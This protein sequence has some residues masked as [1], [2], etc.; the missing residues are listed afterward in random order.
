[1]K[2]RTSTIFTEDKDDSDYEFDTPQQETITPKEPWSWPRNS[3]DADGSAS[4][5]IPGHSEHDF[6]SKQIRRQKGVDEAG[7]LDQ[8]VGITQDQNEP[9]NRGTEPGHAFNRQRRLSIIEDMFY[10]HLF[11]SKPHLPPSYWV[12][13]TRPSHSS[14]NGVLGG[15]RAQ[16]RDQEIA[17]LPHERLPEY[18][19]E[20]DLEGVFM[21]KMEIKNTTKRAEDR[22][23]RMTYVT[24]HGTALNIYKVKKRWQWGRTKDEPHINPDNPPWIGEGDLMKAIASNQ[25]LISSVKLSTFIAWLDGLNAAFSFAALMEDWDFPRD[26]SNPRIQLIRWFQGQK[27]SPTPDLDQLS[28]TDPPQLSTSAGDDNVSGSS[29]TTTT[30]LSDLEAGFSLPGTRPTHPQTT[31]SIQ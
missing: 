22:Q 1:M 27:P 26:M 18:C 25:F 2:S 30:R 16:I 4:D 20:I 23:W 19:C 28:K 21:H 13:A 9:S 24:L 17:P 5:T 14:L 15:T 10:Q 12:W 11:V 29:E 3:L 31:R 6:E 7:H 8:N